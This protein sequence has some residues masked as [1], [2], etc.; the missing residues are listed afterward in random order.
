MHAI[1]QEDFSVLYFRSYYCRQYN[2]S[3][4]NWGDFA[5]IDAV[6]AIHSSASDNILVDVSIV[7]YHQV[8]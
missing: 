6:V 2:M 4:E 1:M 8:Y 3:L 5:L 7:I